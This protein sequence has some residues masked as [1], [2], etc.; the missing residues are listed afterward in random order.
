MNTKALKGCIVSKGYT[1]QDVA[2]AIGI[3]QSTLS[4]KMKRGTFGLDEARK[5]IKL[6]DITNAEEI[7]FGAK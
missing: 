3:S 1:Q 7:F 2:K 4:R 5:L 6:L